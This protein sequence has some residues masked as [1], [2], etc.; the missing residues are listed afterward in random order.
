MLN[1]I[2]QKNTILI[3]IEDNANGINHELLDKIFD[4][5]FTTK[6]SSKG[7]GLGLYMCQEIVTQHMNGEIHTKNIDFEYEGNNYLG[8]LTVIRIEIND[9]I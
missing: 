9:S 7:T 8:V 1:L 4:E 6:D 3:T 5:Y 2:H